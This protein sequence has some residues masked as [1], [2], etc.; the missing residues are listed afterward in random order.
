MLLFGEKSRFAVEFDLDDAPGGEWMFGRICYFCDRN[1][2]GDYVLGTSL[3]DVLFQLERI[4]CDAGRRSN[5]RLFAMPTEPLFRLLDSSLFGDQA[6]SGDDRADEE[7]WARHSI[8]PEVDVFETW[9]AFLVEDEESARLIV[10][11]L[12]TD[13]IVELRLRHGEVD[14]VLGDV[15]RELKRIYA[16]EM[17]G[18]GT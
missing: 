18:A 9:K 10:A 17:G 2:L 3:R 7:Q 5:P 11:Q 13:K 15:I 8:L 14:A 4:H 12:H 6:R 1:Q 16:R